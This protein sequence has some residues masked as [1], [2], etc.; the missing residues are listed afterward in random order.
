MAW[1][2]SWGGDENETAVGEEVVGIW[3]GAEGGPEICALSV[4]LGA[5]AGGFGCLGWRRR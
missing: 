4:G 2:M 1:Q 3:E 5:G